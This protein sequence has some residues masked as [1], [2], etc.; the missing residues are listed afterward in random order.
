MTLK[1]QPMKI[2]AVSIHLVSSGSS[3]IS[4]VVSVVMAKLK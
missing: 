2:N 3:C 4:M 1:M